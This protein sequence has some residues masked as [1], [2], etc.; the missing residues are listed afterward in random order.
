MKKEHY[1]LFELLE[2]VRPESE[3]VT[4]VY[5]DIIN[6]LKKMTRKLSDEEVFTLHEKLKNYFNS[7]I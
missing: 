2:I 3:A 4:E 1:S 5:F 6:M 7:P